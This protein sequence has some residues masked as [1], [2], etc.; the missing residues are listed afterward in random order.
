MSDPME[1]FLQFTDPHSNHTIELNF[2]ENILFE[3]LGMCNLEVS[4]MKAVSSS[5]YIYVTDHFV[6]LTG[7]SVCVWGGGGGRSFHGPHSC[8]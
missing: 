7:T 8:E 4:F 2:R 3:I 1:M 5:F 6:L